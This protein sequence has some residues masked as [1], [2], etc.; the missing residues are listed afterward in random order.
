MTDLK[1]KIQNALDESRILVLGADILLGFEFT[2][3]FQSGFK[4]LSAPSRSLNIIAL[5]LMLITLA[6]LLAPC[7]FHEITESGEDSV[8][9]HRF[10]TNVMEAALLPFALGLGANL[11]IPADRINGPTTGLIFGLATAAT[12]CFFWYGPRLLPRAR[13]NKGTKLRSSQMDRIDKN[14]TSV[15]DKIR[16]V[17]TEARV[18]MPGNQAL[19][20]FQFAVILQQGFNEMD[21][22]LKWIHLASLSSI[23]ISTILLLTP[24]AYHRIVEGGE[25]TSHFYNVANRMT[26]ASLPLLAVG[27]CGDF[28]VVLC[29]VS[30]KAGMSA[31]GATAMLL[32]FVGMWFG[33]PWFRRNYPRRYRLAS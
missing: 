10:A 27:L 9:L 30:Q 6:F 22:W 14:R 26:L 15:H 1:H 5:T 24:A 19:L 23:A 29:K 16:Q 32:F 17:L 4:E 18:I 13:E 7:A 25:E 11:Y 21:M 12:A 28:F 20:G 31:V 8:R 3:V 33:Y 2:A